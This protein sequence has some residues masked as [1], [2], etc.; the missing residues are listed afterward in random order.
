MGGDEEWRKTADTHK[1]S[2]EDV[3]AAGVEESKRPPGHH[4]GEVLHQRRRLPFNNTTMAVG[5]LLVVGA[6]G[7]FTLFVEK[8][9]EASARD[10]AKVTIGAAEPEDTKPRKG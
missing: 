7:Y 2:P 9:P 1:M 8:K 10:V 3:K 5:G 4:P 6:L